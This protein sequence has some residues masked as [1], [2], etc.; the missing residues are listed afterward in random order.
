[1]TVEGRRAPPLPWWERIQNH[2]L[3]RA[4]PKIL[5]VRGFWAGRQIA[6]TPPWNFQHLA[7]AKALKQ[8]SR[9]I[10][11]RALVAQPSLSFVILGPRPE[12]PHRD[13]S[14]AIAGA[15]IAKW[16]LG[17]NDVASLVLV[18]PEDDDGGGDTPVISPL[19]GEMPR[20]GQRGV[21]LTLARGERLPPSVT[22]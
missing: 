8:P 7:E 11:L 17:G 15:D 4:K 5:L 21:T 10:A 18:K 16:I 6:A 2:G 3:G 9:G 12:D 22:M 13:P 1:V 20:E 14:P 19:A